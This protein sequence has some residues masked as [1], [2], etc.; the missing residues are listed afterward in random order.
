MKS[1]PYIVNYKK[2]KENV[3]ADALSRKDT[4]LL[5]RLE[6]NVLGLNDIKTLYASNP[7]FGPIFAKCSIDKGVDDFYLR[8]GFLFKQNKLC[9]PKL[10]LQILLLQVSWWRPYG[11]LW[12]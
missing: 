10:S 4:S 8:K 3:V 1:F 9:I 12:S 11:S 5:A 6:V 2:G 7:S